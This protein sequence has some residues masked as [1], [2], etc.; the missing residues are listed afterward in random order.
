MKLVNNAIN[1]IRISV[2]QKYYLHTDNILD[3]DP[4]Y[5]ALKT[6]SYYLTMEFDD[7]NQKRFYNKKLK[8][9]LDKYSL[10]KYIL[11]IDDNLNKAYQLVSEYREFN[12][13]TKYENAEQE[14]IEL[15]NN[16]FIS[17]LEP[18]VDVAKTLLT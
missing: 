17:K 9:Y 1:K 13:T 15:I 18:L 7:I 14:L 4:Y 11:D 3:N 2:M 5:Y 8:M 12:K 6:F 16:F 10:L